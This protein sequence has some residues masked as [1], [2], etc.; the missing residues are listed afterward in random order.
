MLGSDDAPAKVVDQNHF[1]NGN[2]KIDTYYYI[3]PDDGTFCI[4]IT[5]FL[6]GHG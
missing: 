3:T 1:G 6:L 2:G 5:S 4:S